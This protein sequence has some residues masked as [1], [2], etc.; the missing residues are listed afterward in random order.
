M[1]KPLRIVLEFT[2]W[3]TAWKDTDGAVVRP[4]TA[5]EFTRAIADEIQYK[6]RQ[7]HSKL[8]VTVKPLD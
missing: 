8:K 1:A 2:G 4:P 7:A 6:A 3:N 5:E